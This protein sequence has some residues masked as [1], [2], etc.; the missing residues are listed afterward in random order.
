MWISAHWP[1]SPHIRAFTTTRSGGCSQAPYDSL[2]LATHVGDDLQHV[3]ANRERLSK[4]LLLPQPP[5][6]LQQT[7][8][9]LAVP[10]YSANNQADASFSIHPGE[11]CVV[12]TADCLPIL[13]SNRAGTEV[14]AIHG[15]WRGLL[16]GI[17]ENTLSQMQT[18]ADQLMA[19]LG[20]AI[21]P[22]V[23]QVGNEVRQ[24]FLQSDPQHQ[25]AF[26][27]QDDTHYLANIYQIARNLLQRQGVQQIYGGDFC[28]YTL[29]QQFF[30]Y[31]RQ[32]Q[33]GRMASLIWIER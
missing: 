19:W 11:V 23:Y 33:T 6:W 22:E 1:A 25:N 3:V 13:L 16:N 24:A 32:A 4:S 12:L 30:S 7:H 21:G 17:I 20:P 31:R 18:S 27:A 9:N 26:Q 2:N 28:T 5:Y 10:A 29:Q 15:G 8:S 14:A